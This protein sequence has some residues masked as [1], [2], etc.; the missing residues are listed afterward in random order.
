MIDKFVEVEFLENLLCE[1]DQ[2]VQ[3]K[4]IRA[5]RQELINEIDEFESLYSEDSE[6]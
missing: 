2:D 1:L 4:M 3:R 5:R 6:D